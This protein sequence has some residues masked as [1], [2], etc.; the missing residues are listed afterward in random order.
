ML[1]Q[2]AG[3]RVLNGPCRQERGVAA[4]A[5]AATAAGRTQLGREE[6]E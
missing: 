2:L 3:A 5:A 1:K 4:T 6:E